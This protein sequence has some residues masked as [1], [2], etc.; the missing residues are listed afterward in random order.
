M[1]CTEIGL[2]SRH[3]RVLGVTLNEQRLCGVIAHRAHAFQRRLKHAT[4]CYIS[5]TFPATYRLHIC[6]VSCYISRVNEHTPA[7]RPLAWAARGLAFDTEL[8]KRVGTI[9]TYIVYD[10]VA[11]CFGHE[12][13]SGAIAARG[14]SLSGGWGAWLARN[15]PQRPPL[16]DL[17]RRL[18]IGFV[19]HKQCPAYR[20]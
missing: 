12:P 2:T 7:H 9:P 16:H 15:A 1:T 4:F 10:N 11:Q 6:Y 18:G 13:F 5:A 19:L 17:C 20:H 8:P 14:L 3:H